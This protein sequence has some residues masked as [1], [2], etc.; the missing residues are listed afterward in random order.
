M[1]ETRPAP[2]LS[3]SFDLARADYRRMLEWYWENSPQWVAVWA[4]AR[5]QARWFLIGAILG[6]AVLAVVV[7]DRF[8]RIIDRG[9]G[10]MPVM[11]GAALAGVWWQASQLRK[12]I[13]KKGRAA[14]LDAET[15]SEKLGD[16]FGHREM[17]FDETGFV[18]RTH[19]AELRYRWQSLA[20][21]EAT[22]DL[23]LLCLSTN[24]VFVVPKRAFPSAEA[25]EEFVRQISNWLNLVSSGD[26]HDIRAFLRERDVPCPKCKYNLRACTQSRCPECGT[27][28]D[29]QSIPDAF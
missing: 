23:V 9:E 21:I 28:L 15:R 27:S 20:R 7:I 6:T 22:P 5:K 8:D 3:I 26:A 4:K 29:R 24:A 18:E 13:S 12:S 16:Y 2:A 1:E 14:R 19:L 10:L 17:L 25:T 11:L